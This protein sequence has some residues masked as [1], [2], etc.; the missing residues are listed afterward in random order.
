V[1]AL[2]QKEANSTKRSRWQETIKLGAVI[3]QVEIKRTIQNI[4]RTRNFFF[5]KIN[6]IAKPLVRGTIGHR[7]SILSNKIIN[8]NGDTTIEAKEIQ[9]II[10][11]SYKRLYSTKLENLDE[12]DKFLD[13]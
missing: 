8:E 6:K 7:D 12:M 9:K 4:N 1:K 10:R 11:S 3:N 5:D 2:E 13:R